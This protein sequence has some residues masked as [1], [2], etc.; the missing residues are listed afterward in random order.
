MEQSKANCYEIRSVDIALAIA[1]PI[2]AQ[3]K[4]AQGKK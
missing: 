4:Q 3:K 2:E 1:R